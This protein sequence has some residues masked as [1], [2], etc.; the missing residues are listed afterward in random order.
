MQIYSC[1][2]CKSCNLITICRIEL[3]SK[4]EFKCKKCSKWFSVKDVQVKKDNKTGTHNH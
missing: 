4:T 1:P 3:E 2:Q